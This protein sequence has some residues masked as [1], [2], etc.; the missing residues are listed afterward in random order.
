MPPRRVA[1][2]V[3]QLKDGKRSGCHDLPQPSHLPPVVAAGETC[4]LRNAVR[5]EDSG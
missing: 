1:G 4:W 2:S 3:T 5:K